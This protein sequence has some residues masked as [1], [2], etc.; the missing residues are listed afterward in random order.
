MKHCIEQNIG[1]RYNENGT[2]K[3]RKNYKKQINYE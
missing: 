1:R 2:E 3:N